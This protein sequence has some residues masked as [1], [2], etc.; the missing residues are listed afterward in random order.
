MPGLFHDDDSSRLRFA[1]RHCL[2]Y[3]SLF[4]GHSTSRVAAIES[5]LR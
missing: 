5:Q 4:C 1:V 2:S 3:L